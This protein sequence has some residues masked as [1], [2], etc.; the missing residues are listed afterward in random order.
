ME[1]LLKYLKIIKENEA[2]MLLTS[3]SGFI[4]F[5]ALSIFFYWSPELINA[6]PSNVLPIYMTALILCVIVFL[7]TFSRRVNRHL[8]DWK[9]RKKV[10]KNI[11]Y[12]D[13][14]TENSHR[15]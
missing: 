12:I 3:A 11:F 4:V 6:I 9:I 7:Y 14:Q 1:A 15:Y 10:L 5:I 13:K 8:A 2:D